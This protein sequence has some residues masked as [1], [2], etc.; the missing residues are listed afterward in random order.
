MSNFVVPSTIRQDKKH[1][2]QQTLYRAL[3]G[4]R[5]EKTFLFKD[6]IRFDV[7]TDHI[8]P[9]MCQHDPN[10]NAN[11]LVC[12]FE[13]E[14]SLPNTPDMIFGSNVLRLSCQGDLLLE[15]NA[16][17]ALKRVDS[18]NLPEVKVGTS[19]AWQKARGNLPPIPNAYDWT[20]TSDYD[21]TIPENILVEETDET[22]DLEM[23]KRPDPIEFIETIPLYEDE[24]DD[25][26]STEMTVRVRV[27]P[28]NFFIV[29][30]QYVRS[31]WLELY[32]SRTDKKGG[33]AKRLDAS[34]KGACFRPFSALAVSA[35]G[36]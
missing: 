30:R 25:N 36:P 31:N 5:Q 3:H 26:G 33:S 27:M 20:F 14:L 13:R 21:G 17:D 24:M 6:V 1:N 11:C 4:H 8:L 22:I 32:Y 34:A 15:F 7:V 9:S 19:E 2:V 12:K 35:S 10:E 29:C 23:L 28:T 18:K 16:L